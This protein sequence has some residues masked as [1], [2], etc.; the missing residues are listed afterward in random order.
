MT[1]LKVYLRVHSRLPSFKRK[2]SP[3]LPYPMTVFWGL[4]LHGQTQV[5]HL[6]NSLA[7]F[8]GV[9]K[10]RVWGDFICLENTTSAWTPIS[11]LRTRRTRKF[12]LPK[13]GHILALQKQAT[14]IP[15]TSILAIIPSFLLFKMPS[16][17]QQWHVWCLSLPL[18]PTQMFIQ[19]S[20]NTE[21]CV[22][23]NSSHRAPRSLYS[24][25]R[26]SP[27]HWNKQQKHSWPYLTSRRLVCG[28]ALCLLLYF[29]SFCK[30]NQVVIVPARAGTTPP[31]LSHPTV[32]SDSSLSLE[33]E[34]MGSS[35]V[36]RVWL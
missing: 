3:F 11:A 9:L 20:T 27:W 15:Y 29:F 35:R 22:P 26:I 24:S 23:Q 4:L 7:D 12:G 8:S 32:T 30:K 5:F 19:Q 36:T 16:L 14:T 31:P 18:Y 1:D 10:S 13:T 21:R 2:L 6:A 25:I 28:I 34:S 33:T 17:R